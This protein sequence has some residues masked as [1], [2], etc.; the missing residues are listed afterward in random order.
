MANPQQNV[1]T[2]PTISSIQRHIATTV[3]NRLVPEIKDKILFRTPDAAPLMTVIKGLRGKKATG[4]REVGALFK[5]DMPRTSSVA[6]ATVASDGTTINVATGEGARFYQNASAI[7][8]TT[9][10]VFR[11]VS[12]STDALT[13]ARLG[14]AQPMVQGQGLQL[15]GASFPDGSAKGTVKSVAEVYR[16]SYTSIHRTSWEITR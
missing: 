6:D 4:N 13:V 9:R 16:Y 5:D 15:I 14:N 2:A 8:T 7:N 3:S 11:V 10:E 12:V 1:G